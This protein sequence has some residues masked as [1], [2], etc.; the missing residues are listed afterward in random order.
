MAAHS[1]PLTV[2]QVQILRAIKKHTAEHGYPPVQREI[3][4]MVGLRSVGN[5][6]RHLRILEEKGKL[7]RLPNQVRTVKVTE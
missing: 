3:A 5:I 6:A 4:E 2:K 7:T 1:K